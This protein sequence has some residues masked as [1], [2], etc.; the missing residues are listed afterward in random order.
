MLQIDLLPQDSDG[1]L[2]RTKQQLRDAC[3]KAG[4]GFDSTIHHVALIS[5]KTGYGI[6]DLVDVLLLKWGKQGK[7]K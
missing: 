3:L 4:V 2:R 1:Y 5:A 7:E 6:E